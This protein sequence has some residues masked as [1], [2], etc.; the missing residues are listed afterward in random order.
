[1]DRC[2]SGK[3]HNVRANRGHAWT[4]SPDTGVDVSQIARTHTSIPVQNDA[5]S[6]KTRR[7]KIR[8]SCD[9]AGSG[10]CS[11]CSALVSRRLKVARPASGSTEP[12]DQ[13]VKLRE[14]PVTHAPIDARRSHASFRLRSSAILVADGECP[15]DAVIDLVAGALL[16][17]QRLAEE[18]REYASE[19]FSARDGRVDS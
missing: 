6:R 8:C 3:R 4:L 7:A 14:A 17:L 2:A 5:T 19:D 11:D 1:M 13:V 15:L 9:S 12:D 16:S 18:E 10:V